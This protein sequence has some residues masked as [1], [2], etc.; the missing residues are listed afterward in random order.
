MRIKNRAGGLEMQSE[1]VQS[2]RIRYWDPIFC[3]L[4]VK[5]LGDRGIFKRMENDRKNEKTIIG[6]MFGSDGL[7]SYR[8]ERT[9]RIITDL[10]MF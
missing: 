9:S 2:S 1:C 7:A 10:F 4:K 6:E 3:R 5:G 8:K